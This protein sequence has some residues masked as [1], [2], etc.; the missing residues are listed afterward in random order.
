MGHPYASGMTTQAQKL[1][2]FFRA[3]HQP[4]ALLKKLAHS[5]GIKRML[6]TSN[7]TRFT[8]VHAS[9]ES[10]VRLQSV[11]QEIARQHPAILSKCAMKT[12]S[13][14]MFF[15]RLKQLCKL[16]EPFSLVIA[17]VQFFGTCVGAVT[18]CIIVALHSY[19]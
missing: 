12:I 18:F 6:I 11:L 15:V 10:V 14:D 7:K 2:T 13:N 8:S 5:M 17:A 4:L 1:V 9:L 19:K 3:S 16:Q